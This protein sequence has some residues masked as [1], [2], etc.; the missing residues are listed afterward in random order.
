MTFLNRLR[1][2]SFFGSGRGQFVEPSRKTVLLDP[3]KGSSARWHISVEFS[4]FRL[5]FGWFPH[6][7]PA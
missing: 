5:A 2:F 1:P 7:A 4:L 3:L 6:N